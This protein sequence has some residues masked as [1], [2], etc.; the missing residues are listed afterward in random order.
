MKKMLSLAALC[1][2]VLVCHAQARLVNVV[3]GTDGTNAATTVTDSSVLI[4]T[5]SNTQITTGQDFND[6]IAK[7]DTI[8][9]WTTKNG[10]KKLYRRDIYHFDTYG[11]RDTIWEQ[12]YTDSLGSFAGGEKSA[13]TFAANGDSLAVYSNWFNGTFFERILFQYQNGRKIARQRLLGTTAPFDSLYRE[14]FIYDVSGRLTEVKTI[15]RWAGQQYDTLIHTMVY[16]NGNWPD[17]IKKRVGI[18][19]INYMYDAFRYDA[20]GNVTWRAT[21]S[22]NATIPYEMRSYGFHTNGKI[23]AD[24]TYKKDM[25]HGNGNFVVDKVNSYLYNAAGQC[26]TILHIIHG[27]LYVDYEDAIIMSYDPNGMLTRKDT[28]YYS[29]SQI[30]WVAT[31]APFTH[32]RYSFPTAIAMRGPA[33]K[34][35][36]TIYPNPTSDIVCFMSDAFANGSCTCVIA[37]AMG[38]QLRCW[39][40]EKGSTTRTIPISDLQP[41]TYILTISN[42]AERQSQQ[43]IVAR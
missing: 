11:H 15:I 6:N 16:V 32:Y 26:D 43:F 30:K 36:L 20:M 8:L 42:G 1:L 33:R 37:D 9:R 5:S 25:I 13:Y 29:W 4:Y 12:P 41:G 23:K 10:Q 18:N 28:Y 24:T 14:Y 19:G 17:T 2:G 22:T 3:K 31:N 34:D 27:P 38:R 39:Q 35:N 7:C 21:Y 40:E